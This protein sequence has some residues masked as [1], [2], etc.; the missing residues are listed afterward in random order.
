M[1]GT[2][3]VLSGLTAPTPGLGLGWTRAAEAVERVVDP[4]TV[5]RI[6]V[7]PPFKRD[8]REWGTAVVAQRA[9]GGRFVLFTAKYMLLT[10]GRHKGRGKTEVSEVGVGP[11]ETVYDVIR[12]VQD[13]LGEG[14]PPVEIS[15]ELWFGED[16]DE[17][18][19]QA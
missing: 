16:D 5:G 13:R 7:F 10:R 6:W 8:G 2:H 1:T 17:P 12:G 15:P 11:E 9:E 3:A 18:T 19:A 14:E 4:D